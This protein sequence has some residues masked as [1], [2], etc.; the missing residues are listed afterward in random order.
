MRVRP[1]PTKTP[2]FGFTSL[3]S[4]AHRIIASALLLVARP[5]AGPAPQRLA[6]YYG[7]PSLINGAH[8]DLATVVAQLSPFDVIVLGDGLEFNTADGGHAGPAEHA[9]T[10]RLIT[11]L[12][13]SARRPSVFGYV[14]L[15]R[16]QT[17]PFE[18]VVDRIE[19]WAAMGVAGIFFDEA[20]YD[21]GVTRDRQNRAV[22]AAR[23]RGLRACLNAFQPDDVFG[24]SPV[25]LNAAG[26]GNPAATRSV[27][28]EAD[29]ILIEPFAV[30]GG[31]AEAPAALTARVRAALEGRHRFGSRVFA[32]AAGGDENTAAAY[33]WWLAAAFGLD[34]YGWSEPGYGA[35]TSRLRWLPPPAAEAPLG[36][37]RFVDAEARLDGD[38]WRRVTTA[39]TVVVSASTQ[40]ATLDTRRKE[41]PSW[42][43][44]TR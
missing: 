37:A 21:F 28:S 29:A 44:P 3:S 8:G 33:G 17:L 22:L 43:G 35:A 23:T 9:F 6:V 5:S 40:R 42:N 18:N 15:G 4:S 38:V 20:G 14:D 30:G 16:T 19:R 12:G 25:P 41:P 31:A 27:M 7:Y 34:A 36:L 24:E 11:Q 26:G 13:R 1:S 10:A 32:I 39:G 2:C